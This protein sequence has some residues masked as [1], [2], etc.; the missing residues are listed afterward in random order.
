[1]SKMIYRQNVWWFRDFREYNISGDVIC[2]PPKALQATTPFKHP[3]WRRENDVGCQNDGFF[4]L[5]KVK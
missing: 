3:L 5:S 1:M 4:E 2:K